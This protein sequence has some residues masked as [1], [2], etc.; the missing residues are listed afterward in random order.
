[1]LSEEMK[2]R[3]KEIGD[4]KMD[5]A[6][7]EK[8]DHISDLLIYSSKPFHIDIDIPLPY[9]VLISH[10]SIFLFYFYYLLN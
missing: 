5:L 4:I 10:F 6:Q 2:E 3:I 7:I 1:M 8:R 9:L